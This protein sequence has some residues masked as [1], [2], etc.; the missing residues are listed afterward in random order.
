MNNH[1]NTFYISKIK[2]LIIILKNF[3]I[4]YCNSL[5]SNKGRLG[6][7]KRKTTALF[8]LMATMIFLI[9]IS[10]VS[11]TSD[12]NTVI[13]DNTYSEIDQSIAE[14]NSDKLNE[15][16]ENNVDNSLKANYNTKQSITTL[17]TEPTSTDRKIKITAEVKNS[18]GVRIKD[19]TFKLYYN[20]QLIKTISTG[21]GLTKYY[22]TVPGTAQKATI[23][24]VY[25]GNSM[26]TSSSATYTN[27]VSKQNTK[28][29]LKVEP[30]SVYNQVKISAEV[31]DKTNNLVPNSHFK[32]YYNGNLIKTIGTRSGITK[33]YYNSPDTYVTIKAEYQGS[34][35]YYS[36]NDVYNGNIP[37]KKEDTSIFISLKNYLFDTLK[38]LML[39]RQNNL[40]PGPFVPTPLEI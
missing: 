20:N 9:G 30:T 21:S 32:V 13:Q 17:T 38:K 25:Q 19:S 12:N 22:Y 33:F 35:N 36:S 2:L 4:R 7:F 16:Y 34:A 37:Q 1:Y 15:K 8:L 14:D 3:L 11:A 18:N 27:Y 6:M 24:A 39:G 5:K 40:N 26:Y 29:T 23:K 10:V 28:T 31:R